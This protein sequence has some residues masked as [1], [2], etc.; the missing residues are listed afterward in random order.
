MSESSNQSVQ[1]DSPAK[2]EDHLSDAVAAFLKSH[3]PPPGILD[4]L[5]RLRVATPAAAP[6]PAA[7]G[8]EMPITLDRE[9]KTAPLEP[10][11][12]AVADARASVD[13]S[14]AALGERKQARATAASEGGE[15]V[16]RWPSGPR[17][18]EVYVLAHGAQSK[19][20]TFVPAGITV[21]FY[22][23][24]G[25]KLARQAPA[26]IL[27]G[28]KLPLPEVIGSGGKINNY[29][30]GP[31]SK[32]ELA[33]YGPLAERV[34]KDDIV[35][36][37]KSPFQEVKA[38]CGCPARCAAQFTATGKARHL[39]ECTGLFGPR[40][41]IYLATLTHMLTCRARGGAG[42]E[43][44]I[45]KG[46]VALNG[47]AAR[48]IRR[49]AGLASGER[50][51]DAVEKEFWTALTLEEVDALD[52]IERAAVLNFRSPVRER[53]LQREHST[54]IGHGID[55]EAMA[56]AVRR[57]Q[58]T[59]E[60]LSTEAQADVAAEPATSPAC[61]AVNNG[62]AKAVA[63]IT[64][65]NRD[66]LRMVDEH[67]IA[68]AT[69]R[70]REAPSS[71]AA[72]AEPL[73]AKEATPAKDPLIGISL[74]RQQLWGELAQLG[75]ELDQDYPAEQFPAMRTTPAYQRWQRLLTATEAFLRND[76]IARATGKDRIGE[77]LGQSP[78]DPP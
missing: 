31:H 32:E 36:V 61:R 26:L 59:A 24:E 23:D 53:Y 69:K 60:G 33:D 2:S 18:G 48:V 19:K 1:P 16:S 9:G 11:V 46:Q 3:V 40:N 45:S 54:P 72:S 12:P 64:A 55:P 56:G 52:P 73:E 21:Q 6:S 67:R 25:E 20:D 47:L 30:L 58:E 14:A 77:A 28:V 7:I 42:R 29:R 38:L 57:F 74:V 41:L 76:A 34:P 75:Q 63:H 68:V 27:M 62:L 43:V 4:Q 78:T 66:L 65:T 22:T 39:G 50:V 37:G 8:P 51:P 35:A 71:P 15:G 17:A 70:K 10:A 49:R 44:K 13:S 5:A